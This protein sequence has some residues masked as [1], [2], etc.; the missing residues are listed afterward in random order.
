MRDTVLTYMSFPGSF[1][2]PTFGTVPKAYN[3]VVLSKQPLISSHYMSHFAF[4][5]Y[6]N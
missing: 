2:E 6:H 1:G 5:T 3:R 4:R